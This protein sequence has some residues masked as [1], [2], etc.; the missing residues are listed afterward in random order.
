MS[1]K[2]KR[3]N[4]W[5][6]DMVMPELPA[7]G[8]WRGG[9]MTRRLRA[10]P[11][12]L[13]WHPGDGDRTIVLGDGVATLR[14]EDTDLTLAQIHAAIEG[15]PAGAKP[16]LGMGEI[17]TQGVIGRLRLGAETLRFEGLARIV[18]GGFSAYPGRRPG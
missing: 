6:L 14:L 5:D 15:D 4:G 2:D 18:I 8:R 11:E 16:R 13:V 7:Q 12:T 10:G 3:C 9:P 17:V 1:D